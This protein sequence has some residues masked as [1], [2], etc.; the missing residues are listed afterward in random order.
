[1]LDR[2]PLS[3][4]YNAIPYSVKVHLKLNQY[5]YT[6]TLSPDFG[7]KLW[8]IACDWENLLKPWKKWKPKQC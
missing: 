2:D 1:M 8:T 3:K 7:T 4:L 5:G 6:E